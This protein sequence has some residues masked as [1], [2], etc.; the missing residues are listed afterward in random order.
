MASEVLPDAA[1]PAADGHLVAGNIDV[2]ALEIVLP[3]AA[4][5]DD[6]GESGAAA[7]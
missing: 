3:G 2:D 6:L 1:R 5:L 7:A 4:D